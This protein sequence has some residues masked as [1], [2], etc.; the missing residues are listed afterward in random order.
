MRWAVYLGGKGRELEEKGEEGRHSKV[1]DGKKEKKEKEQEEGE[2]NRTKWEVDAFMDGGWDGR[3]PRTIPSKVQIP[4]VGQTN[5]GRD[6]WVSDGG[7][8]RRHG[9]IHHAS[10]RALSLVFGF[11]FGFGF[12]PQL[13]CV[14]RRWLATPPSSWF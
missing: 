14:V 13:S 11:G 1:R 8:R 5:K 3:V 2:Q 12:S 7:K 4:K 10:S 9:H 6:T